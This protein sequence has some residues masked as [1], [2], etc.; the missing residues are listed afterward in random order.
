MD[1]DILIKKLNKIGIKG[2]PSSWVKSYMSN[3]VCKTFVNSKMST[4]S[5]LS[6]GVPQGSLL[7][8]LLF[9]IYV[10]DLVTCVKSCQV[11]LYADDTVLYFS[12]SSINNIELA[13]NS[14]LVNVYNW[15]CQNKLSVNCKKQNVSFLAANIC[16]RNKMC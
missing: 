1:C 16:Y 15:M 12:H 14:D 13:L 2:I 11:Q 3:R 4:E 7:G 9:I 6:C 10:N 8:P 5:V